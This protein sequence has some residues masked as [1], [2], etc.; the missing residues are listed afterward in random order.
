MA[1]ISHVV[2]NQSVWREVC[3]YFAFYWA[4]RL[5]A[6]SR[7]LNAAAR[8]FVARRASLTVRELA[9]LRTLARMRNVLLACRSLRKLEVSVTLL[10][11]YAGGLVL[12]PK[13]LQHLHSHGARV[14]YNGLV[15]LL[16]ARAGDGQGLGHHGHV[17]L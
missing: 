2:R 9:S 11:E 15:A 3:S 4:L 6:C 5:A 17:A 13:R 8:D 14:L 12:E 7:G 16:A 10:A 1:P